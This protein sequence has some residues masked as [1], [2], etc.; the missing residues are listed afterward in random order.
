MDTLLVTQVETIQV[1]MSLGLTCNQ[2]KVYLALVQSGMSKAKTI[3]KASNVA[4]ED[5]YRIMPVLQEL[6]LVEKIIDTTSMYVAIPMQEAFKILI[7]SRKQVTSDLQARTQ[8]IIQNLNSNN[9]RTTAEEETQEFILFPIERAVTKRKKM[10]DNAQKSI[11]FI[12]S[13]EKFTQS[14]LSFA[15]DLGNAL[16]K[17]VEIR[18][19]VGKLE[20]E[21]SLLSVTKSW[22]EKYSHFRVHWIP[23]NPDAR[24]ML[25]DNQKVL[26][27][28]SATSNFEET[29]FLWS[30]NQSLVSV[31]K[32]Y[33]EMMWLTS[34]ETK[35]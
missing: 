23:S 30:T 15:K 14:D 18:V 24:L 17:R 16:K 3:S 21:K 13:W 27:A 33:F 34:F 9:F 10:I 8:T 12:T 4:R 35:N 26:F 31:M 1:L 20:D 5:I 22:R 19:I 25:I 28:K 6:G 29:P 2:A 11:N 32:D 7:K